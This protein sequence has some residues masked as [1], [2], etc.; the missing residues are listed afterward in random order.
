MT[1]ED[2]TP[3]FRARLW[4]VAISIDNAGG[5]NAEI[6]YTFNYK[7]DPKFGTVSFNNGKPVFTEETSLEQESD[8]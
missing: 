4:K 2:T 3:K 8:N 7:G 1:D 6:G 5:E